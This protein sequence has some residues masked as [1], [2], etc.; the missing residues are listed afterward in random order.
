MSDGVGCTVRVFARGKVTLPKNI[1]ERFG[2]RDED[3]VEL[4]I[5]GRVDVDAQSGSAPDRPADRGE[6]DAL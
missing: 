6:A 5:I 1:R 2:I 4:R 3:L